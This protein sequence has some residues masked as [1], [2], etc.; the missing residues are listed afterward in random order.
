MQSVH[1]FFIV[2]LKIK[3]GDIKYILD[4]RKGKTEMRILKING[5]MES[6]LY[7]AQYPNWMYCLILLG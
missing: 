7:S 1:P 5:W 4:L 3:S 6:I 2:R